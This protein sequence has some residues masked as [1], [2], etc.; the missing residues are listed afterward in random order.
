[1]ICSKQRRFHHGVAPK[2]YFDEHHCEDAAVRLAGHSGR[3]LMQVSGVSSLT[4]EPGLFAL[5]LTCS[6][7]GWWPRGRE[8]AQLV[9]VS[10]WHGRMGCL[11][12]IVGRDLYV[13]VCLVLYAIMLYAIIGHGRTG[14]FMS[15]AIGL[16]TGC[17]VQMFAFYPKNVCI[18][19]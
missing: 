5:S 4:M 10:R 3:L 11:I 16:K 19:S 7:L 17:I 6:P 2:G 1:M 8:Y 13:I 18:L 9:V 14:Y 12:S 15:E